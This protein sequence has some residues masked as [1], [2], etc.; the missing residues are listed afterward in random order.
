MYERVLVATDG[1]E[2][3]ETAARHAMALAGVHGATV[4]AAFVVD[5]DTGW[6]T[7]SKSEVRDSLRQVGQDAGR[8]ALEAVERLATEA[9]VPVVTELL[10]GTPE[11][12]LVAYAEAADVDLVVMGTHGREGVRRRLL[13]SVTERVVRDA[14]VPVLTVKP[15][16][17]G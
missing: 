11:E 7:V 8:E 3:A 6:L 16:D 13:G 10:E 4:H 1:G 14:P 2:L 12:E 17:H 15:S 9:G 5:T